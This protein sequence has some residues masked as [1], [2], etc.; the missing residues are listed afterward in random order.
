MTKKFFI[1]LADWIRTEF[2]G[3]D[4]LSESQLEKLAEFLRSQNPSFDRERWLGY[5]LGANGPSG[6][7]R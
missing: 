3:D 7:K 1:A 5:I 2:T 4:T 6:G